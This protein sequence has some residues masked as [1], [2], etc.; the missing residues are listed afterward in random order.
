MQQ[1]HVVL[2]TW[3]SFGDL[4]PYLALAKGL[5]ARGVRASIV[6]CSFYREKVERAGIG[7]YPMRPDL[8]PLEEVP[9]LAK[10]LMDGQR[11]TRAIL[12]ELLMPSLQDMYTDIDRA[13]QDADLLFTHPTVYAGPLVAEKRN[14]KWLSGVL[15]PIVFV[16]AYD[17]PVPS[18]G[19]SMPWLRL[20]PRPAMRALI[21]AGK[22][23]ILRWA[24]EVATLRK[25]LGLP[26]GENPIFEGQFSPYGTIALFSRCLA[27]AQPDWPV[28]VHLAGFAFYDRFSDDKGGL[29]PDLEAFLNAGEPPILFTLGTSAVLTAG[30]FY[31]ESIEAVKRL[32]KRAVLLIGP[33]PKNRPTEPLPPTIITAVY[34]PHSVLMPRCSAV[35]HQGGAGTTGQAMRAGCPQIIVPFSH[36]QPDNASRIV[37]GGMGRTIMRRFYRSRRVARELNRILT[38]PAILARA[39]DVGRYMQSED[40]V[41]NAC[42]IIIKTMES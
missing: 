8:P 24:R 14:M 13:A 18:T 37:R 9:A 22:R 19:P 26:Q 12:R 7:F 1:K 3:G 21:K 17:P 33:D 35:V 15:Q 2:T 5:Q 27:E 42:D 40:G 16:S 23:A 32:K 29:E 10:R 4:H 38:D 31:K 39:A 36:D 30:S 20:L 28:K 25:E 6:T 41:A 11:G 34:A